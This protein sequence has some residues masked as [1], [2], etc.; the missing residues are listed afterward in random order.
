MDYRFLIPKARSL[1]P[2]VSGRSRHIS[3]IMHRKKILA[4][5]LANSWRTNPLSKKYGYRFNGSH[6]ELAAIVD[7]PYRPSE[8]K[9]CSMVNF[10]FWKNGQ[11]ANAMPCPICKQ[12]LADFNIGE[13]Y[14]S[15]SKGE[16]IRV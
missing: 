13:I 2:E 7:F 6:S 14:Y 15:N 16:I 9:D 10:R 11:I 5:G 3:F 12:L 4:I 8:L 1:A